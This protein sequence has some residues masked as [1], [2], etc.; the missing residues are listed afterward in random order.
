MYYFRRGEREE[1]GWMLPIFL[2]KMYYLHLVR[3]W[4]KQ[5]TRIIF[6]FSWERKGERGW[7]K[8]TNYQ[9]SFRSSLSIRNHRGAIPLEFRFDRSENISSGSRANK[10]RYRSLTQSLNSLSHLFHSSLAL[11]F[12]SHIY[13]D[14]TAKHFCS[15][16]DRVK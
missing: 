9:L 12:Y 5:F 15:F 2:E 7:T 10:H 14:A 16:I 11:F 4:F 3:S 8:L 1:R 13:F 6:L